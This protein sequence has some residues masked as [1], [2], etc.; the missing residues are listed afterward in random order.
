VKRTADDFLRD[1]VE[2][3]QHAAE[4]IRGMTKEQFLADRRSRDAVA[5]CIEDVGE[6]ANRAVKL[7][8]SLLDDFEGRAA[9]EMRNFLS[10]AYFRIDASVLWNAAIA[11]LPKLK[12]DI[13]NILQRR[14]QK[15]SG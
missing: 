9:Y 1:A 6:A 14:A 8:P 5:K 11:D 7:D 15:S 2:R 10:H 4:H 13:E 12:R 3:A